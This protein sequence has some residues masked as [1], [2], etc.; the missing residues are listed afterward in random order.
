MKLR[1][2]LGVMQ[3]TAWHLTRRIRETWAKVEGLPFAGPVEVDEA[4]MGGMR[5]FHRDLAV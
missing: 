2:D 3:K 5:L 1:R 4:F